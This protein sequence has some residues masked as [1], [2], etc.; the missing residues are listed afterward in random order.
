MANNSNLVNITTL[1]MERQREIRS[2]GGK[3][4]QAKRKQKKSFKELISIISEMPILSD[5]LQEVAKEMGV[6]PKNEEVT[7]GLLVN[8]AQFQ[9]AIKEKDTRSAEY[10]RDTL[11][12]KPSVKQTIDTDYE[13]LT[14]LG[15]LLK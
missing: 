1:S 8:L 12:E 13:D 14:G 6:N 9:K 5:D 11:G 3:A 7:M 10:I 15:E 4:S 2:M